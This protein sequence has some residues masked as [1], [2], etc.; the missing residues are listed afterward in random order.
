MTPEQI[1]AAQ[2]RAREWTAARIG[3]DNDFQDP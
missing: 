2:A 3:A 1:E